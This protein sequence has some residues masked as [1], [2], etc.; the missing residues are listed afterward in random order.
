MFG[1]HQGSGT[2]AGHC[3]NPLEVKKLSKQHLSKEF[4]EVEHF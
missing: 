1:Y 2:E 3:S 4:K